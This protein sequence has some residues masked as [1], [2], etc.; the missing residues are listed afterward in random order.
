MRLTKLEDCYPVGCGKRPVT[1]SQRGPLEGSL[2]GSD[3]LCDECASRLRRLSGLSLQKLL[4][5]QVQ[6]HHEH[7]QFEGDDWIEHAFQHL[8]KLTGKM[9]QYFEQ[10]GHGASPS[11]DELEQEVVPDLLFWFLETMIGLQLTDPARVYAERITGNIKRDE[12]RAQVEAS[13]KEPPMCMSC[14]IQMVRAG[15]IFACPGCGNS[16]ERNIPADDSGF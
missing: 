7:A 15:S 11:R 14:G 3:G 16:S 5:L 6:Y 9:A 12:E 8:V 4:D 10:K 2:C 1:F 13:A